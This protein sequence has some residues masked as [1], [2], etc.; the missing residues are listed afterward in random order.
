MADD[1]ASNVSKSKGNEQRS[2]IGLLLESL[3]MTREDLT[4]HS[5]QMREFL[6]AE[7]ANSLRALVHMSENAPPKPFSE[8]MPTNS[9]ETATQLAPPGS[10][11]NNN[12]SVVQSHRAS[13]PQSSQQCLKTS[14]KVSTENTAHNAS[15]HH[16]KK[17]RKRERE[18]VPSS[19]SPVRS[20]FSLDMIM[21]MRSLNSERAVESEDSDES[22]EEIIRVCC[23]YFS[24]YKRV[25][26]L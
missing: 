6:T 21:Q 18:P 12:A 16:H 26:H 24:C 11:S 14:A 13:T 2:P 15:K 19:A 3:G 9:M 1:M 22:E 5:A 10:S 4:R 20:K 25:F 7:N 23:A 8:E 17:S